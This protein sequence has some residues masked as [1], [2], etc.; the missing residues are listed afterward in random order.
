ME[1]KESKESL[2]NC[3]DDDD[4]DDDDDNG[5]GNGNGNGNSDNDDDDDDDQGR[6]RLVRHRGSFS[7]PRPFERR[8]L[9]AVISDGY[10][11]ALD[12][13]MFVD[14][15]QVV[16]SPVSTEHD[17]FVTLTVTFPLFEGCKLWL[18]RL[19][20]GGGVFDHQCS[21]FINYYCTVN[22]S[23]H[24]RHCSG[25]NFWRDDRC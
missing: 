9:S 6:R 17:D 24:H 8:S 1:S 12:N 4:D 22:I 2:G 14:S 16:S 23:D 15:E 3:A 13:F 19:H 10:S 25:N 11:V 5:N 7:A 21:A 20:N 18:W